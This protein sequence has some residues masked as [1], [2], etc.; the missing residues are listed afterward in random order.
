MVI[1]DRPGK[2][3]LSGPHA[4]TVLYKV[5]ANF[6]RQAH[7]YRAVIGDCREYTVAQKAVCGVSAG[8]FCDVQ[9]N[10]R[11]PRNAAATNAD[12]CQ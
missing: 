5:V 8:V 4:Q 10:T 9:R 7:A 6:F 11:K 1:P 2:Q 3:V 12:V